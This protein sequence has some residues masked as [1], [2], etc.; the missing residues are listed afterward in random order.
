MDCLNKRY[1]N[2]KQ[3]EFAC[4]YCRN[5]LINK[6]E[7]WAARLTHEWKYWN[8]SMFITLTY[9]DELLPD[10]CS[11]RVKDLQNFF[12]YVRDDERMKERQIKY[13]SVIVWAMY[14]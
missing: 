12:H 4:G 1:D 2:V 10:N 11:L 13:N 9:K 6:R 5:C 14:E 3:K 8:K 7:E